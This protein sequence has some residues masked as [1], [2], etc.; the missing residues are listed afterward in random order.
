MSY[1]P[2]AERGRI[3]AARRTIAWGIQPVSIA[4]GGLLAE[5]VIGPSALFVGSGTLIVL[6]A[7]GNLVFNRKIRGLYA[8]DLQPEAAGLGLIYRR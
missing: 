2:D 7:L 3:F 5:H 4:I 8:P 1:T 6:I